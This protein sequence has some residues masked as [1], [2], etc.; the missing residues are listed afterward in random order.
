M[1]SSVLKAVIAVI[2]TLVIF[3]FILLR[4][5]L[6]TPTEMVFSIV[7]IV[8]VLAATVIG[9]TVYLSSLITLYYKDLKGIK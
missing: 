1:K 5:V 4:F 8:T 2:V 3:P 9:S 7:F 6:G